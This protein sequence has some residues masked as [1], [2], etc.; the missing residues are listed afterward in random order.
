MKNC[1]FHIEEYKS[2]KP[3][4]LR[5]IDLR[6]VESAKNLRELKDHVEPITETV[7]NAGLPARNQ[8]IRLT[9]DLTPRNDHES[10]EAIFKRDFLN[11]RKIKS[12]HG[13][14]AAE[15]RWLIKELERHGLHVIRV[16]KDRLQLIVVGTV[17]RVEHALNTIIGRFEEHQVG[18]EHKFLGWKANP[19]LPGHLVN[20]ICSIGI[21]G[22]GKRTRHSYAKTKAVDPDVSGLLD[23]R[24]VSVMYNVPSILN[25]KNPGT[26]TGKGVNIAIVTSGTF[27][28]KDVE[29]YL[30]MFNI[31]RTGK[32]TVKFVGGKSTELN[33]ETT[34]DVQQVAG[35]AP[36]ADITV[37]V[38]I[39]PDDAT[40]SEMFKL[41]QE[42]NHDLYSCS[43]G[44]PE[45]SIT[46]SAIQAENNSI[47]LM[48][49]QGGTFTAASGDQ[50]AYDG[51]E[52]ARAKKKT[53][54]KVKQPKKAP[55]LKCDFPAS[56]PWAR[57]AGGT[58]AQLNADNTIKIEIVWPG[59]G[60]GE[61]VV[62]T[63]TDAPYQA[64]TLGMPRNGR[65]NTCDV[66]G[67]A[68]PS[69]PGS[70]LVFQGQVQSVGGT[71]VSAPAQTAYDLAMII[72]ALGGK[73]LG[74][75]NKIDYEILND[76]VAYA[77]CFNDI[78]KGDNGDGQGPGYTAGR[79][80][81]HGSGIGSANVA[82]RIVE[83]KKR[84]GVSTVR[85]RR[86]CA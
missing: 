2:D 69:N 64:G 82:G 70:L 30:K 58:G 14:S 62:F 46:P 7:C 75:V 16:S 3:K 86:R 32:I 1:T 8:F 43:W 76:P 59:S 44:G 71:S 41:A 20:F 83:F 54:K 45:D 61:S 48:V 25:G 52:G 4:T 74:L 55:P 9:I 66:S 29:K 77:A 80:F 34:L 38:A 19:R 49:A 51:S 42:G 57:A 11:A 37:Y 22:T 56:S 47:K 73:R 17:A 5:P 53:G 28:P 60:G 27:D 13:R 65:R 68:D 15:I 6:C 10:T 84:L 39:S 12:R 21:G 23:P 63:D 72:E 33:I 26:L 85:T 18:S 40:F 81:D 50:G 24:K 35:S 31:V 36:G 78:T 79:G 67:P